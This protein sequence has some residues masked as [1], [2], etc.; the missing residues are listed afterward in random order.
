MET[1]FENQDR[2]MRSTCF[3]HVIEMRV[4]CMYI[5]NPFIE[6]LNTLKGQSKQHFL[7]KLFR[8]ICNASRSASNC[9]TFQGYALNVML[10]PRQTN[11]SERIIISRG[12]NNTTKQLNKIIGFICVNECLFVCVTKFGLSIVFE[13]YALDKKSASISR[14]RLLELAHSLP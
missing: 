1:K 13:P 7:G 11:G 9:K 14:A 10:P 4:I 5:Y 12:Q 8:N 3:S 6:M 2:L